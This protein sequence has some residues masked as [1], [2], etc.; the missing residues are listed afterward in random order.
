MKTK[1]QPSKDETTDDLGTPIVQ[2]EQVLNCMWTE[3]LGRIK[4]RAE[5]EGRERFGAVDSATYGT[6]G[7][8]NGRGM[9]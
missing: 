2:L 8:H 5:S 1:V 9:I 3:H 4:L 6:A 7:T